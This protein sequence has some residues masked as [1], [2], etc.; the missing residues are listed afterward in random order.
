MEGF[1]T[2]SARG[3]GIPTGTSPGETVNTHGLPGAYH[4][5]PNAEIGR[6]RFLFVMG[7][8]EISEA[9]ARK[10]S[11]RSGQLPR[12]N[13]IVINFNFAIEQERSLAGEAVGILSPCRRQS[14]TYSE[15][16]EY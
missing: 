12:V 2:K 7:A 13:S 16:G 3:G 14:G 1:V 15:C 9:L 4:R 10:R 5:F 8:Q 6:S 11:A